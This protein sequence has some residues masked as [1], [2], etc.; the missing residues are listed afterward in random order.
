MTLKKKDEKYGLH[1]KLVATPGKGDELAAILQQASAM[2]AT[3]KGCHLYMVS[4]DTLKEEVV[5]ITEVWDTKEDHDHSLSHPGVREL[6]SKA[7]PIL[8]GQPEKGMEVVV[9]SGV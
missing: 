9:L 3:A 4:K 6:I 1:G 7:I 5:W 8:D 2:M